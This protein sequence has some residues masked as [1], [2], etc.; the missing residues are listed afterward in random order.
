MKTVLFAV[1]LV[2]TTILSSAADIV[3]PAETKPSWGDLGGALWNAKLVNL[4]QWYADA[5]STAVLGRPNDAGVKGSGDWWA[6]TYKTI[7]AGILDVCKKTIGTLKPA[8]EKLRLV[9]FSIAFFLLVYSL[10][11]NFSQANASSATDL[12]KTIS[13]VVLLVA[14]MAGTPW[15]IETLS[16]A[17]DEVAA[18]IGGSASQ[19]DSA[20]AGT[21][22]LTDAAGQKV[23]AC[24]AAWKSTGN[25]FQVALDN[26]L[27]LLA[28]IIAFLGL[29]VA[30]TVLLVLVVFRELAMLFSA[31]F[32]PLGIAMLSVGMLSGIGQKWIT[33]LVSVCLWPVGFALV[34]VLAVPLAG[35]AVGLIA[36]TNNIF[37]CIIGAPILALVLVCT[38]LLYIAAIK[39]IGAALAGAGDIGG[40]AIGHACQMPGKVGGAA[41]GGAGVA[42]AG[43]AAAAGMAKSGAG[44]IIAGGSAVVG[45]AKKVAAGGGNARDNSR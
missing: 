38:S 9:G 1:A 33:G 35:W 28:M 7:R 6:T 25:A 13:R 26:A 21:F 20:S 24:A 41:A 40:G 31:A 36:D 44:G 5:A 23:V 22:P 2:A 27:L 39:L 29:A 32:L 45:M 37:Q 4:P 12:Q 30:D 8:L 11:K 18:Q 19:V 14:L 16:A 17:G 10:V 34:N 15:L 43:G 42:L 3:Q